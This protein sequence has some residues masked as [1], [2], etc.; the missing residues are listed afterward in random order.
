[1]ISLTY[2]CAHRTWSVLN[3]QGRNIPRTGEP[4]GQ[5]LHMKLPYPSPTVNTC[6]IPLQCILDFSIYMPWIIPK[7]DSM[8]V[9][10]AMW[11]L[12]DLLNV[13]CCVF[14]LSSLSLQLKEC[15]F[16]HDPHSA[17]SLGFFENT[18]S[19]LLSGSLHLVDI[20]GTWNSYPSN[21]TGI[22]LTK[23]WSKSS[24][25][26]PNIINGI[27]T[28][29]MPLSWWCILTFV[30]GKQTQSRVQFNSVTTW[31]NYISMTKVW[32]QWHI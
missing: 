32:A 30:W 1:M 8:H 17:L 19:F 26:N 13:K 10:L 3:K 7:L 27:A 23:E 4:L 24:R 9:Q 22:F 21:E 25:N 31:E 16:L 14:G 28:S 20:I 18:A 2:K 15:H 29:N 5:P 11:Y 6:T 12:H